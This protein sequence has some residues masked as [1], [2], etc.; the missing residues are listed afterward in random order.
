MNRRVGCQMLCVL[1]KRLEL[2]LFDSA[3]DVPCFHRMV[4]AHD[5]E[6]HG[7]SEGAGFFE[8]EFRERELTGIVLAALRRLPA[9]VADDA[10]LCGS[11]MHHFERRFNDVDRRLR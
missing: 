1:P 10:Y 4:R 6:E 9:F 5:E 7:T 11:F 3:L 2:L 8:F